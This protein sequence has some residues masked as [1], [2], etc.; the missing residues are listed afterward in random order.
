MN[1]APCSSLLRAV[2]TVAAAAAVTMLLPWLAVAQ[3][4]RISS[5]EHDVHILVPPNKAADLNYRISANLG[6]SSGPPLTYHGGPVMTSATT[7][8]IYWIPSKLQN[9]GSTS[10]SSNYENITEALLSL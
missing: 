5:G 1:H 9:G 7:Y 3:E 10:V 8:A 2:S 4:L 6:G